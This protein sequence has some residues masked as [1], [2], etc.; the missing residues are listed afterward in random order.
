MPPCPY[1]PALQKLDQLLA[2]LATIPPG[3]SRQRRSMAC[4]VAATQLL[5]GSVVVVAAEERG[6]LAHEGHG[7]LQRN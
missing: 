4:L 1:Q 3:G 2:L 5:R 6:R 7:Q